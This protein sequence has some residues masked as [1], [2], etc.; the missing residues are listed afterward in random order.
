MYATQEL[1]ANA[2]KMRNESQGTSQR[3]QTKSRKI[4]T[5][6]NMAEDETTEG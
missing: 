5:M 6:Q 4:K 2:Q 3:Q 1:T